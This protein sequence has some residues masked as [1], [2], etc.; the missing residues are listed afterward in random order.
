MAGTTYPWKSSLDPAQK[1]PNTVVIS[2]GDPAGVGP[3]LLHSLV[4]EYDPAGPSWLIF[5]SSVKN[6]SFIEALESRSGRDVLRIPYAKIPAMQSTLEKAMAGPGQAAVVEPEPSSVVEPGKP[7]AL[8]GGLAFEALK[9]S[10]DWI[11]GHGCRGLVTAPLSKEH[12]HL[13]G[14]AGFS[15]HTGYLAQRFDSRVLMLM[16]GQNFSVL[17]L[18]VHI[19]L[20]DVPQKLKSVVTDDHL[21]EQI[22]DIMARPAFRQTRIGLCGLNPHSGENGLLGTE[23]QDYLNDFAERLR[24][25]ELNVDGPLSADGLFTDHARKNYRLILACYHDQGLIPFK[26]LEGMNGINATIGLPFLRTSPDH[27]TAFAL[28]GKGIASPDS[29]IQSYRAIVQGELSIS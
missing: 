23:E 17:P 29:L 4:D 1:P 8:S 3:E 2:A 10:C 28:A 15:G 11:L 16:H 7:S 26:S 18:T 13:S 24:S 14:Q 5:H 27:G 25:Q 20:K 21:I 9:A 19:P 6:E 12:V 22:K